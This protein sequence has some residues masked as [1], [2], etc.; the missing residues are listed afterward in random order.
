MNTFPFETYDAILKECRAI[1]ADRDAKGRNHFVSLYQTRCH[2]SQ[3]MTGELWQRITR[4]LGAEKNGDVRVMRED[5][6][7][8]VNEAI[9][10][11]MFLDH[12]QRLKGL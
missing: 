4:I 9:L 12:E 1:I 2:G 11:V 8:L 5:L 3:D 7:D 6:I 10:T